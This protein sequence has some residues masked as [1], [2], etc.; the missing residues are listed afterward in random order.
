MLQT[1]LSQTRKDLTKT[2][3]FSS[4]LKAAN[5][6]YNAGVELLKMGEV[7]MASEISS[8][9]ITLLVD[10]F[11]GTERKHFQTTDNRPDYVNLVEKVGKLGML[12]EGLLA[13][14][15]GVIETTKYRDFVQRA[16]SM[17]RVVGDIRGGAMDLHGLLGDANK[18]LYFACQR[19]EKENT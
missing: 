14:K 15:G 3:T 10:G 6:A 9:M 7:V 12:F 11:D 8:K 17:D 2:P 13:E 18:L 4:R 1:S 19:S 5:T 16:V